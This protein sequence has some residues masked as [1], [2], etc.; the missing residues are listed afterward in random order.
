MTENVLSTK[1]HILICF[2][3]HL[4]NEYQ[5]EFTNIKTNFC[6]LVY[7]N[8]QLEYPSESIIYLSGDISQF[9]DVGNKIKV[10][11]EVSFNY[12]DQYELIDIGCVPLNIHNV[13]VFFPKFFN[14]SK[15]YF[16]LIN[17][18]HKFQSLTESNKDGSAL[19]KGIY[20]TRVTENDG[21]EFNL[22]RCSS[23]LRG[24]TDNLRETDVDIFTSVNE[25]CEQ[26]FE[27]KVDLNHSLVQIYENH[28]VQ[29]GNRKSERKAKIKAHSDKTKD[30]PRNALMAFCTF[31]KDYHNGKFNELKH[32]KKS[33]D[34]SFDCVYR[35]QTV[36]TKLTFKL[37]P[38]VTDPNLVKHFDIL[39]YPNSVFCMSLLTN[40]LYTHEI[41]P[42][43]LPIDKIPIRMGYVIRCSNTKA[44]HRDKT[45]VIKNDNFIELTPVD[46]IKMDELKHIYF[47]ENTT[48]KIITYG[49]TFFS[50][51]D[52]DYMKPII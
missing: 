15:N 45:Y 17:A 30:M 10:I 27:Q 2:D 1:K 12:G 43:V 29:N 33:Y 34:N 48:D 24:P 47:E 14:S 9:Y 25:C 19:R 36:L 21:Y 5:N 8:N 4:I 6:G 37:K 16:D 50:L 11:K 42:N 40:R 49:D 41:V 26:F 46:K 51:N 7:S 22:L 35:G 13:G 38:M 44:V 18:E 32:I 31:Y 23:N 52:G 20:L 39:L 28:V 3:E